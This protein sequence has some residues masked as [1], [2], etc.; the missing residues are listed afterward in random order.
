MPGAGGG[1]D[2]GW[3]GSLPDRHDVCDGAD[4]RQVRE[5]ERTSRAV[6]LAC[7]HCRRELEC[8]PGAREFALR[9]GR[10][11]KMGVHDGRRIRKDGGDGVVVGD[12]HVQ[13]DRTGRRHLRDAR[14]AA[15]HGHNERPVLRSCTPNR[16]ERQPVAFPRA[17]GHVGLGVES[18]PTQCEHQDG[19]P[20][21]A[22]RIEVTEHH[23]ALAS[24]DGGPDAGAETLGV[25]QEHRVVQAGLGRLYD[26][27]ETCGIGDPATGEH[28]E[29]SRRD[30]SFRSERRRLGGQRLSRGDHPFEAGDGIIH[31]TRV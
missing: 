24:G 26:G 9:V 7:E 20:C 11:G 18:Q 1:R 31:G 15:I 10:P 8:D 14:G 22:V 23:D 21:E 2:A 27:P 19:K 16:G 29:H 5:L 30:S 25:R 13:A 17:A 4:R 6:G 28:A 12:E 3:R